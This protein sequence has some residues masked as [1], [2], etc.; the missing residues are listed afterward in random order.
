MIT[1]L[2]V[3]DR[4]SASGPTRSMTALVK[5]LARIGAPLQHRVVTLRREAYPLALVM[6][7]QAGLTVIREPDRDTLDRELAAAD[8]VQL[9]YWNS[10]E[11]G[12]LLRSHL[13]AMRLLVWLK[14][15]GRHAPQVI[16]RELLRY[17][18]VTVAT[19]PATLDL[20]VV[21]E[22]SRAA[23]RPA[24]QVV[25]GIADL[26]RLSGVSPR[27]HSSFN[28]GYV[29]A[30]ACGKMHPRYVPMSAAVDVPGV[31][32]VICGAGDIS[33][34]QA[35]AAELGAADRFEWRGFVENL[36]PVLETLDVFGYPLCEDTYATS[37]Q[38]LQEAMVA[39]VPPVVFPHGGVK[40][41]V[42][43][44]ET[45]LIVHREHEYTQAIEHLYHHP[46]ERARLGENARAHALHA[47]DGERAARA[48]VALYVDMLI[49]PKRTRVWGGSASDHDR[50]FVETLGDAAPEFGLSMTATSDDARREADR[51]I[52]AASALL[53]SGEGGIFHYRNRHPDAP[54]LR[55]WT[56]LVLLR[57]GRW[58]AAARELEAAAAGGL[59][60]ARVADYL[61]AAT[62]RAER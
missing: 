61:D 29:G 51:R 16:T 55:L 3:L 42:E 21:Q 14:I 6:T 1:I 58:G 56:G 38:S 4:L 11:L 24:I 15:L 46:G 52:A 34:L 25:P 62:H 12:D 36:K 33:A 54:Y 26:D 18:D 32:F 59:G 8:I 28:V 13:P 48:F 43:D 50:Q 10:P 7:R 44:G 19:T 40:H 35:E 30:V 53:A 23:G 41:L 49:G 31:R 22:A 45:G 60:R 20:P 47:F 9:H 27:P 39:R 5:H 2:H 57:R 17:A 37:E